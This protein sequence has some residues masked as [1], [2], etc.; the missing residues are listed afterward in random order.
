MRRSSTRRPSRGEQSRGITSACGHERKRPCNLPPTCLS[1]LPPGL[2]CRCWF[3]LADVN[4]ASIDATEYARWVDSAVSHVTCLR[5]V[6]KAGGHLQTV[7]TWRADSELLELL[8]G[9]TV[10]PTVGT[11]GTLAQQVF[12]RRRDA[13]C[14][15]YEPSALRLPWRNAWSEE[16]KGWSPGGSLRSPAP[17]HVLLSP[18]D[19][20]HESASRSLP[21]PIPRQ[22]TVLSLP[23]MTHGADPACTGLFAYKGQYPLPL[24]TVRPGCST[25]SLAGARQP[26]ARPWALLTTGAHATGASLSKWSFNTRI[27]VRGGVL[28]RPIDV[29]T[30]Q[31]AHQAAE[32]GAAAPY[33]A[34][35]GFLEALD[36]LDGPYLR[37]R[38]GARAAAR[39]PGPP[40]PQ[41]QSQQQLHVPAGAGLT[42][43]ADTALSSAITGA[44][45]RPMVSSHS[46]AWRLTFQRPSSAY[47]L[48]PMRMEARKFS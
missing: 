19:R 38:A 44:S 15:E 46:G 11:Y 8:R 12:Q 48:G 35:L 30:M 31:R 4:T 9:A 23:V 41:P 33:E 3:Q 2:G 43:P 36:H 22:R 21:N 10:G 40:P 14:A 47:N 27:G 45:C 32:V 1:N 5:V 37:R 24:P 17:P 29:V 16:C 7:V 28:P 42:D 6:R 18:P 26:E 13:W 39:E 34:S 20:S 25:S